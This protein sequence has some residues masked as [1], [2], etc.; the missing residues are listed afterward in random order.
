MSRQRQPLPL[1][2]FHMQVNLT[3][4][5]WKSRYLRRELNNDNR[6]Q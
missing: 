5:H 1:N 6:S 3:R 4:A 2:G